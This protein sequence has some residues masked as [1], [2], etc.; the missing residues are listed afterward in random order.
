MHKYNFKNN[1]YEKRINVNFWASR[2]KNWVL[3]TDLKYYLSVNCNIEWKWSVSCLV[4]S[5]SLQTHGLYPTRIL[6]LRDSPGKNTGVG[7]HF[8]LQGNLPRPGMEP[9]TPALAGRFFTTEP[10]R[11]SITLNRLVIIIKPP[12]LPVYQSFSRKYR[13]RQNSFTEWTQICI[14]L[15]SNWQLYTPQEL[16]CKN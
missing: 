15:V 14:K 16:N 1:H 9:T 3:K 11:K 2:G 6:C 7:C 8:L 13:E 10:P 5:Y 12:R 4:V